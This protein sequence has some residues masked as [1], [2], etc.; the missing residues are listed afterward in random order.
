MRTYK[1]LFETKSKQWIETIKANSMFDAASKARELA[2]SK[3]QALAAR[4]QFS[5]YHIKAV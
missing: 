1:F 4:I 3:S 5:F 2:I